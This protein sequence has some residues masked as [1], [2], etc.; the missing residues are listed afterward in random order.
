MLI[1]QSCD[2]FGRI[3]SRCCDG[4]LKTDSILTEL[5]PG[6][7]QTTLRLCG[8]RDRQVLLFPQPPGADHRTNFADNITLL[9]IPISRMCD[10]CP[11]RI[12]ACELVDGIAALPCLG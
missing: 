2:V 6:V 10:L 11:I 4:L 7:N 5:I 9:Q 12:F 1:D 3:S 8:Q